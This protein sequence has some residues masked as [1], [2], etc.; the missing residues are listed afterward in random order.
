MEHSWPRA[1]LGEGL[2]ALARKTGLRLRNEQPPSAPEDAERLDEWLE[3]AAAWLG[4]EAQA[5]SL[6]HPELAGFL[7]AAGPAIVRISG[8]AFLLFTARS[9][10]EFSGYH[11]RGQ[12]DFRSGTGHPE[13]IQKLS[14]GLPRAGRFRCRNA[15]HEKVGLDLTKGTV[16]QAAPLEKAF[17]IRDGV[18]AQE[19]DY[20]HQS[21]HILQIFFESGSA[22]VAAFLMS[23][24]VFATNLNQLYM[25]DRVDERYFEKVFDELPVARLYR[26]KS[27]TRDDPDPA[28]TATRP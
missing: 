18:V 12:W 19:L 8:D 27:S 13:A 1:R 3:T 16:W 4:V 7:R 28:D 17:I 21:G 6:P 20:P 14:C 23:P 26:V 11:W 22:S 15:E 24:A 9:P 25:L 2:H 5:L 10:I